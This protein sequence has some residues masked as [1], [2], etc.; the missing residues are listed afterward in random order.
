[1]VGLTRDPERARTTNPTVRWHSWEPT[2]E[3]PPAE[4]FDGV[5]G[6]VN[7]VGEPINQRWSNEAKER[8]LESRRAATRNLV[9]AIT[10]LAQKPRVLVSQSA[11]GYY[12]DR[13]ESLVDESAEPGSDFASEVT[14]EWEKAASEIEGTGVRLVIVRT[15][16]VLDAGDGP[17]K[18]MLTPFKLGV[19]GPIGGG[20]QYMPWIHIDD[21]VG[22]LLWALDGSSVD[23]VVNA[24]SPN[25]VT[26]RELSKTLG[27]VLRRPAVMPVPGFALRA[28][29]GAELAETI[30][31]GARVIPRRTQDLGYRFQY[32]QLEEALRDLVE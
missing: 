31:G 24:T 27:R 7:L 6:V 5:D 8:I 16:L 11:V 14:Q 28:M 25:P 29:F 19:G 17:L 21:E 4:A 2:M 22:I 12:G 9:H 20:G 30:K 15:G 10:G 18:Q 13:G 26:N 3:R 23:G 1:V 32:P